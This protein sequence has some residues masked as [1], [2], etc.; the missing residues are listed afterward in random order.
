MLTFDH[1]LFIAW[2]RFAG[3]SNERE[4]GRLRGFWQTARKSA[5]GHSRAKNVLNFRAYL[6]RKAES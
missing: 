3:V 6:P 5:G 4:P 2:G 1:S